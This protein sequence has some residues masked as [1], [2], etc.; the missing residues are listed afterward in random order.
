MKQLWLQIP[1]T[2]R[3]FLT[4]ISGTA[5]LAVQLYYYNFLLMLGGMVLIM[6][7][8]FSLQH[9][10]GREYTQDDK[11]TLF[12]IP[13]I[14]MFVAG[15]VTFYFTRNIVASIA[16]VM[17]VGGVYSLIIRRILLALNGYKVYEGVY[18]VIAALIFVIIGGFLLML[19]TSG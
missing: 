3:L 19:I 9:A 10:P 2:A 13:M 4:L 8:L 17:F 18:A 1:L 11:R 16:G 14:V 5:L 12:V 15:I 7:T 6:I